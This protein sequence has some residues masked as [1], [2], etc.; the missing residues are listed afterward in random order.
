MTVDIFLSNSHVITLDSYVITQGGS[1]DGSQYT[2][3]CKINKNHGSLSPSTLYLEL[4]QIVILFPTF[5][6]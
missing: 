3:L 2:F 6:V 4:Y 1:N 5:Y